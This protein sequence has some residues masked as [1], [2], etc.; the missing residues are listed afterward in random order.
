MFEDNPAV[1]MINGVPY[2]LDTAAGFA[3]WDGGLDLAADPGGL[4]DPDHHPVPA[5]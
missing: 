4:G 5:R 2:A 1:R 3:V